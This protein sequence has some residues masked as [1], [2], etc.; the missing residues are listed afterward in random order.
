MVLP[1]YLE[2]PI[3]V[4]TQVGE[5]RLT[6]DDELLYSAPLQTL[7]AVEE[8]NFFSRLGDS[9]YLFYASIF[10]DDG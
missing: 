2:A 4:A 10:S 5:I 6:L 8:S 9:I 1:E 7:Q 3:A